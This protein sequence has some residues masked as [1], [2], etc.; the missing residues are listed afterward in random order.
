MDSAQRI[1]LYIAI[2]L[3]S[4]ATLAW[5]I[6]LTRLFAITQFY[7]FAFLAVNVALLGFGASGTL[8]SLRPSWTEMDASH[9]GSSRQALH[10]R[11]EWVA[12]A[13]V[14]TLLAGYFFVNTLPFDSYAIAWDRRQVWLLIAYY[15][16]LAMPFFCTGL[17]VGM[18]LAVT[19]ERSNRVYSANLMGSA[20]GA[21]A[22]PLVLPWLGIPGVI[23]LVAGVGVL[24]AVAARAAQPDRRLVFYALALMVALS[25]AFFPPA[26]AE[27]HLSPYKGLSQAL[28]YPGSRVIAQVDSAI[29]R[30]N[31]IESKGVRSLPG[32]SFQYRGA[33]PPQ[34]GL[35]GDGDDLSP[36]VDTRQPI[37]WAFLDYLPEALAYGLRPDSPALVLNPRGGLAIWQALEGG[38]SGRRVVTIE[39]D[40]GVLDQL[41]DLLGQHSPYRHPQV[42]PVTREARSFLRRDQ[43]QFGIIHLA[44]TQP[45]RP[46]TS[47]AFSLSENYDLTTEAVKAYLNHLDPAGMLVLSRWL[48]VPPSESV[49]T[50]ALLSEGL[51]AHRIE[52]PELHVVT[53]RGVQVATFYVKITPWTPA[54][55]AAVREFARSRRLDLA[56]APDLRPEET[57]QFNILPEPYYE[58][59]YRE[60]L[61]APDKT[62][63][64]DS[65]PFAVAPPTDNHPF[66]FHFFKWSQTPAVLR[67]LGQTWQPFGGSGILV[68][69]ALL[70]LAVLASLFLILVPL[71]IRM[72]AGR[73]PLGGESGQ[74]ELWRV[75]LYFGAL[76][77]GFLLV[78]IPLIQ[79]F[80]LFLGHPTLA[81]AAVLAGLLFWSG[82]GS[83]FTPRLAWRTALLALLLSVLAYQFLLEH[84]FEL[85]LGAAQPIRILATLVLLA[86]LGLLMGTPFPWGLRWLARAAPQLTAWAWAINGCTSVVASVLAVLL[87]LQWGFD[88]V[89]GL[90]LLSYAV[91]L[92]AIWRRADLSLIRQPAPRPPVG[93]S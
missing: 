16:A 4:A 15:L 37:D 32:L 51:R 56:L 8:L 19:R 23:F 20:T 25:A 35:L 14:A 12:V 43:R 55:L 85:L 68:L 7:H 66:F 79:R 28:N 27:L 70:A 76:G 62:A 17:A 61:A 58:N 41:D 30:L 89:M 9:A 29:A 69:V 73:D 5:E 59:A 40:P 44:L 83:L 10:Q 11:L 78:E 67:T 88:L 87:A 60:L 50:L 80:I 93:Q 91:A 47:G 26:A 31:V 24:A 2:F 92:A 82:L 13:F 22:A 57:N 6:T 39:P 21:L 46:V 45:Y 1:S 18:A 49:R 48:Q 86:P 90:G 53:L 65:Q 72:R 75:F 38:A 84:V 54:E 52:Q 36:V 77:L 81:L 34:Y 33:L 42:E 63:F 64:Y 71:A 74:A 3:L